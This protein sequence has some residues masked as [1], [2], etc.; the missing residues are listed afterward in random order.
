MNIIPPILLAGIL[1]CSLCIA[2]IPKDVSPK[3]AGSPSGEFLLQ[4]PTFLLKKLDSGQIS[5]D[6]A[7]EVF[8]TLTDNATT[9][10]KVLVFINLLEETQKVNPRNIE[11]YRVRPNGPMVRDLAAS[12]L[13]RPES[14]IK[15][16]CSHRPTENAR[17]DVEM[18]NARKF[19]LGLHNGDVEK[20]TKAEQGADGK[21][22]EAAQPPH[23]LT[24]NTRLP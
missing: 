24:P 19:F 9:R 6:A 11:G 3:D 21:P 13:I 7:W 18:F 17:D 12:L 23:K 10:D 20:L 16:Y 14:I 22:P 15:N 2:E 1:A 4:L 5:A 8:S